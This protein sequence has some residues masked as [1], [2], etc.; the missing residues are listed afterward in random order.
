MS[1]ERHNLESDCISPSVLAHEIGVPAQMIYNY[2]SA[3]RILGFKCKKHG[4]WCIT[5]QNAQNWINKRVTKQEA[6]Y[7][8]I[9]K[10]LKGG[11]S[12]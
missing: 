2:I 11:L 7:K 10:Q 5:E 12:D 9:Q 4:R 6:K 1:K 8:E 3:G